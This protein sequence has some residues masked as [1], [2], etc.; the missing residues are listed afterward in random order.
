M[1]GENIS[2]QHKHFSLLI[3]L[4]IALILLACGKKDKNDTLSTMGSLSYKT[5]HFE[6]TAGNCDHPDSSCARISIAYP[7]IQKAPTEAAKEEINRFIQNSVLKSGFSGETAPSVEVLM[8][9]FIDQYKSVDRDFPGYPNY[10]W[11][12]EKEMKVLYSNADVASFSLAEQAFT[13]GAHGL[14][15]VLYYNFDLQDGKQL[16][17]SNL[18]VPGYEDEL[19]HIGEIQFRKVKQLPTGE[20]LSSAGFW[21]ENDNFKL[22]D[23]FAITKA[24]LAFYYNSYEIGPYAMGPTELL[25]PYENLKMIIPNEG[26][27]SKFIQN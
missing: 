1:S 19:I 18:F 15:T 10:K 24:G 11:V 20:K 8:A 9:E 27:L 16:A 7:E 23:N 26:V 25:L 2:M 5:V 6:K 3:V 12:D 21:F 4:L 17:L 22:N 13:G 14:S